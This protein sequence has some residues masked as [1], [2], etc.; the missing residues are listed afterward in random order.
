MLDWGKAELG[1]NESVVEYYREKC[2]EKTRLYAGGPG[3]GKASES[4]LGT[5]GLSNS[6]RNL[7]QRQPT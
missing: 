3:K 7:V 5:N 4:A 1:R 2:G 6:V